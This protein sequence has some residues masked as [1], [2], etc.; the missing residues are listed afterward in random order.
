MRITV[1]LLFGGESSE[2]EVSISSA[3]NV[4]AALDDTKYEVALCYIDREGKWWLLENMTDPIDTSGASQ[5][6]PE[7]G[8][9]SFVT[10]SNGEK[11]IPNV[12]LPIL[13]GVNGEDGTVQGLAKLTHIP[14]VG[15]KVEASSVTMDKV[16]T[17][18]LLEHNG[19]KTVPFEVHLVG[20]PYQSF[21]QL[22]SC[23]GS[24]L[25]IK[26][27]NGG[28][29]VGISKVSNDE[30]L[31]AALDEAHKHD[32]KVL[33]E[34][35]IK[36]RE[37]EVA[38]LGSGKSAKVSGVGEIKPD[39]EF[40]DYDSK[41]DSAS[42]TEAIIPADIPPD[43]VEKIRNIAARAYEVLG[44]TGLSRV[45]FFLSETGEVYLNEINTIPGFTNISMYPKLWR[46]E[47]LSYSGLIDALIADA[48]E[49]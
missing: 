17:K 28:S 38:V 2:H 29:S 37:I 40:Y 42:Q 33:I 25:F 11:I 12:L 7:L 4:F 39:R 16:T 21:H 49:N 32:D 13:H 22:S 9:G 24:S 35:A 36:A 6:L 10:I 3:R 18:Q 48:L 26:P 27:A 31:S 1:L 5:L 34:T 43:A 23:L 45:D 20:E 14:I 30:D 19:I 46:Q 44:C 15:C 8:M 47:G 41:Y